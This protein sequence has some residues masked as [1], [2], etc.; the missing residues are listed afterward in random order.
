MRRLWL[1]VIVGC[2]STPHPPPIETIGN[3]GG[4]A[5]AG[6]PCFPDKVDVTARALYEAA[7]RGA[8]GRCRLA[9]ATE[10]RGGEGDWQVRQILDGDVVVA[11][12]DDCGLEVRVAHVLDDRGVG[13]GDG[14]EAIEAAYPPEEIAYTTAE[15]L[16]GETQLSL[17]M[18]G[19]DVAWMTLDGMGPEIEGQ[20]VATYRTS[21]D[22]D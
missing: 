2:G 13:V 16:G 18:D 12:I 15:G 8:P 20:H 21:F 6:A 4:A 1:L 19:L 7:K 10:S 17:N 22:C 14:A 11:T 5:H 3:G 9:D